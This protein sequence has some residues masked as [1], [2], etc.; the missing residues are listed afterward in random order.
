MRHRADMPDVVEDVACVSDQ[1]S[2]KLAIVIPGACDRLLVDFFALFIEEKRDGR[3]VGLRAVEADVALALL[4]GIIERMRVKEG[5]DELA[6]DVFEAEFKMRVLVDRVVAAVKRR[7]ADAEALLVGN[8]FGS[9]EARRIAGA[10]GGD[11]G[12]ERMRESIPES[13]AELSGNNVLAGV[14]AVEHARLRG[15]VGGLFYRNQRTRTH[16]FCQFNNRLC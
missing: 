4:L 7:G 2:G 15:H 12:I 1:K 14:R 3:D 5:P 8:L 13:D 6:A 10:R 11:G 9:D 16:L